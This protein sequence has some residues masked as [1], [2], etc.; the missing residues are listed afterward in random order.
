NAPVREGC[1]VLHMTTR[2]EGGYR[3]TTTLGEFTADQVI[4]A[5]G[6]YHTPIIPRFAERLPTGMTQLHSEQYRS[7][8]ALPAGSVLLV[9]YRQSGAQIADD[10]HLAGRKVF[11]AVGDAP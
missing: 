11:L 3:L 10:L 4:V 2:P 1:A 8:Q 7:P 6:G 5:S 9:G